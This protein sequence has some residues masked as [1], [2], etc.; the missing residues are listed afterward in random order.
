MDIPVEQSTW[1]ITFASL[2][3]LAGIVRGLVWIIQKK[4]EI[5]DQ[6]SG[7]IQEP[8]DA[9]LVQNIPEEFKP[10]WL[11]VG[12]LLLAGA[13]CMRFFPILTPIVMT[14]AGVFLLN[15]GGVSVLRLWQWNPSDIG[16][17]LAQGI[18]R[19]LLIF[20]PMAF[21]AAGSMV[22]FKLAGGE[23]EPQPVVLEFL[24]MENHQ[25]VIFFVIMAV[26]VAPIWEEVVFRGILYPLFR[27][28]RD[29]V[30]AVLVTGIL[31]GLVHAHGPAFV[32][33]T[34]LGCVLAWFY[35]R[36]GKL[37]YCIGLH[38][39]FNAATAITLLLVKYAPSG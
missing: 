16:S 25:G 6:V 38:A 5:Q 12:L 8:A 29:R 39:S 22:A 17:Y 37:G 28:M 21:L 23:A 33:L 7:P 3:F 4:N 31:F 35:E 15:K 10:T 30:F 11:D 1:A 9:G 24:E 18:D 19:Y 34:F 20:I 14:G 27:G 2:L 26:V 32:P 13:I 36:T